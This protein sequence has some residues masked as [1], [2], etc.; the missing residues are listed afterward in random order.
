MNA[1]LIRHTYVAT[2]H[3]IHLSIHHRS[4]SILDSPMV[5]KFPAQKYATLVTMH[6]KCKGQFVKAGATK[7][8]MKSYSQL[9]RNMT[10]EVNM[11]INVFIK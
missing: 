5:S 4:T 11:L 1:D 7:I 3:E 9:L 8:I 2:R 10:K 6:I